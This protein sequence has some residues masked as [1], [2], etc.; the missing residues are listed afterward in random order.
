MI[1]DVAPDERG[2]GTP[3]FLRR[4]APP[5]F[6]GAPPRAARTR[7]PSDVVL[8]IGCFAAL[9][10]LAVVYEPDLARDT[11]TQ[12]AIDT[13]AGSVRP[14]W[15]AAFAL[16]A[17]WAVGIVA[18]CLLRRQWYAFATI[19][20][21][22]LLAMVG[23]LVFNQVADGPTFSAGGLVPRLA[24]DHGPPLFPALRVTFV[25][26][27]LVAASPA[28]SRPYRR[29]GRVL[30]GLGALSSSALEVS[31]AS[32]AIAGLA[33]GAGAAAVMH[34]LVGS[35]GGRPSVA[36][37]RASVRELEVDVPELHAA[38]V[39]TEG[40]ARLD[41]TDAD[42]HPVLVKVYGRDAADGRLL[43]TLWRFLWYR[44]SGSSLFVSRTQQVEHEAFLTLM[45]RRL[46]VRVADVVVAGATDAGDALLVLRDPGDALAEVPLGVIDDDYVTELWGALARVHAA[47]IAHRRLDDDSVR[48]AADGSVVLTHW[49]AAKVAAPEGLQ[50][51]DRAQLLV[52]TAAAIGTARAVERAKDALGPEGLAAVV[53]YLQEPV[54]PRSQ[55][56]VVRDGI[57]DLDDVRAEATVAA[58]IEPGELVKLRRVTWGSI[59]AAVA[60]FVAGFFLISQL[61]E[62]GF[63]TIIRELSNAELAWVVAALLFGQLPRLGGAVS[64]MGAAPVTLP[65]GPTAA[66]EYAI[67]FVNLAVPSSV[68]R[69]ATKLRF[70][71]KQGVGVV[72]A[73]TMSA[74]DSIAL[75]TVQM[76]ILLAGMLLGASV[77][78]L[79]IDLD[80]EQ[81]AKLIA[82][83]AIIVGALVAITLLVAPV[84][85]RVVPPLQEFRRTLGVLRSPVKAAQLFLGNFGAEVMFAMTIGLCLH[86]YGYSAS[87]LDL[88]V[89]NTSVA[90]FSGLMPVPGGIGITE[91]ALTAGLVAIGIPDAAAFATALTYRLCTF[92]LPPIWGWFALRWLVK[93][94]YL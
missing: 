57:V 6:F 89:V 20:G 94:K 25:A 7:R 82:V 68:G 11:V 45:A 66:L 18:V 28:L 42:G 3:R 27:I 12:D 54:L 92:Y 9:V 64:T 77:V 36:L 73:G 24:D 86:A 38:Q 62:I 88:L 67:S 44:D 51:A 10:V 8:A 83:V 43:S 80:P 76:V 65:F 72:A 23:V 30:L 55:R 34:V 63:D 33:L 47:G 75:F 91:A 32:G 93:N 49:D 14:L 50:L 59:A 58:G 48:R 53:P 81:S 16:F 79:Q 26:A 46:G 78:D 13:L 40:V 87:L 19:V 71:Q 21:A 60:L 22:V 85:R 2:G 69:M 41:G 1:V 17:L 52:T 29:L 70:L 4:I 15:Q 74:L 61:A 5:R 56:H 37:V 90:L 35:P 31:Y 39:R 84:R